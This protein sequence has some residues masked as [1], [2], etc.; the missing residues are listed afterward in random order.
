MK[1]FDYWTPVKIHFGTDV[2]SSLASYVPQGDVLLIIDRVFAH[3]K[4]VEAIRKNLDRRIRIFTETDPNPSL[5]NVR[6]AIAEAR[7]QKTM[8][9]IWVVAATW[10]SQRSRLALPIMTVILRKRWHPG[11]FSGPMSG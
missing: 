11:T 7:A 4:V 6:S 1:G 5:E 3:G 9:V 2:L 10:M 8:T